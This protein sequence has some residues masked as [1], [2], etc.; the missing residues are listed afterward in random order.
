V[1]FQ[2]NEFKEEYENTAKEIG[3]G[4]MGPAIKQGIAVLATRAQRPSTTDINGESPQ[5]QQ[6]SPRAVEKGV[7]GMGEHGYVTAGAALLRCN[8]GLRV[9][10]GSLPYR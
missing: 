9:C 10:W 8:N 5:P 2:R 3:G 4:I 1:I 6:L 7:P